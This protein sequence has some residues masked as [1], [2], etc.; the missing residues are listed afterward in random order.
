M[1][2]ERAYKKRE[3]KLLDR[4]CCDATRNNGF[5]PKEDQ[6]RLDKGEVFSNEGGEILVQVS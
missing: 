5:N 6:F 3:D 4:V 2:R 1:R